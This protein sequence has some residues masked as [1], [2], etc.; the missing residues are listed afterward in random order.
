MK[1][2]E[3]ELIE[4]RRYFHQYPELGKQE[5][6]TTEKLISI[7]AQYPVT[8]LRPTPT[9]VIATLKGKYPG[10]V[11]ALR[12]DIDALPMEEEIEEDFHS[13][14]PNIAHTCGH[15]THMAMLLESCRI[16]CEKQEEIHGTIKFIFQPCE[17]IPPGG[18]IDLIKSGVLNDVNAFVGLHIGPGI[19]TGH[20]AIVNDRYATT[21]SCRFKV[22]VQGKGGH[23]GMPNQSIDPIPAACS[24]ITSLQS[25]LSREIAPSN[26]GVL[27]VCNIHSGSADNII[28]DQCTF[29]GTIRTASNTVMDTIQK[30]MREMIEGIGTAYQCKVIVEIFPGYRSVENDPEL[31][32]LANHTLKEELGEEYVEKM[33]L[34]PASEDFSSYQQIAPS[35]YFHLGGGM[36]PYINHHPKFHIEEEALSYGVRAEVAFALAY[37]K[38]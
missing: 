33:T 38:Q 36:S 7:L 18:A 8:L 32:A 17:E 22:T 6:K 4:N 12:A 2:N 1:I 10:K 29:G 5:F 9:G 21:A 20:V 19:K 13:K 37:L 25:I 16:L 23:G 11:L 26:Y 27:S 28:P 31:V 14:Y 35:V 24:M 34:C 30:R 15:D 3:K